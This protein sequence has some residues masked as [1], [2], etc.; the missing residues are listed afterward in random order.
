MYHTPLFYF[1]FFKFFL[2]FLYSSLF[3]AISGC[4]IVLWWRIFTTDRM[5]PQICS[6]G[7]AD[8]IHSDI[9]SRR[10][11]HILH[12][13]QSHVLLWTDCTVLQGK[14]VLRFPYIYLLCKCQYWV[15]SLLGEF[16]ASLFDSLLTLTVA[17]L[18]FSYP[19]VQMY[20]Y[21]SILHMNRV[22]AELARLASH[23]QVW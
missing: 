11:Q 5:Y 4:N 14:R 6:P 19:S 21:H 8:G 22:Q 15:Q 18:P 20:T 9:S 10:H 3:E 7:L 23:L 12:F 2:N 1:G 13:C 16:G 17:W